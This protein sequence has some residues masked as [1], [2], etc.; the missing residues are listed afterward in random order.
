MNLYIDSHSASKAI[1][2]SSNATKTILD[3]KNALLEIRDFIKICCV[4]RHS[5]IEGNELKPH[6]LICQHFQEAITALEKKEMLHG[7]LLQDI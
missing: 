2:S 3:R 5:N 6:K 1:T 4:P 7:N